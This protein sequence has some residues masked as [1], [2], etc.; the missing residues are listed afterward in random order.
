MAS[1]ARKGKILG[2]ALSQ[3]Q[4]LEYLPDVIAQFGEEREK[5][6]KESIELAVV[7]GKKNFHNTP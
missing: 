4:P 5:G 7:I 3:F 2:T 1:D 6:E